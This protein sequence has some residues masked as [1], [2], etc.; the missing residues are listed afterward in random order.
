MNKGIK[1]T[2]ARTMAN[3]LAES[4]LKQYSSP[5]KQWAEFASREGVNLFSSEA[6]DI[7]NFFNER[8]EGGANYGTLNSARS[9]IAFISNSNISK[10]ILISRFLRGVF[11][12]KPSKPKY[13]STWDT[14]PVLEYLE[15]IHPLNEFG[16]KTIAEKVATLLILA[17][18]HRLQTLSLIRTENISK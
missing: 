8:F 10:D 18:A 9:A 7:I 11:R 3:A 15:N 12:E 13:S 2:A 4:T 1:D 5:L 17:T 16:H 6:S 14:T